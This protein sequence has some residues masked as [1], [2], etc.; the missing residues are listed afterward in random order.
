MEDDIAHCL[1][2][3][4]DATDDADF[5]HRFDRVFAEL[6][7]DKDAQLEFMK[8]AHASGR[9][10]RYASALPGAIREEGER[11]VEAIYNEGLNSMIGDELRNALAAPIHDVLGAAEREMAEHQIAMLTEAF[12]GLRGV[13]ERAAAEGLSTDE[14]RAAVDRWLADPEVRESV[15]GLR[16]FQQFRS[17]P[18]EPD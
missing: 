15:E 3:L 16:A 17:K 10:Y 4:D 9:A 11:R 13:L 8:E 18:G 5:V 1:A 12:N 14:M 2:Y 6:A 7:I